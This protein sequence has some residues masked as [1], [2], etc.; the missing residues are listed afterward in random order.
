[1]ATKKKAG[2]PSNK[3]GSNSSKSKPTTRVKSKPQQRVVR[4]SVPKSAMDSGNPFSLYQGGSTESQVDFASEQGRR[5]GEVLGLGTGPTST[6]VV[7]ATV[8][9]KRSRHAVL[10]NP[11]A[12]R[13]I[14]VLVSNIVGSGHKMVSRA[15]DK[16]F[17]KQV[18][19]LWKKWCS[20]VDPAG[21][22]NFA[23]F[24]ALAFRSMLEGGD[25]FVRMRVRRPEDGLSV[26]LQLQVF[27][28]EQV[29]VQKNEA[30][31]PN[32]II[33]GIEFNPVGRITHYHMHRNH[34][35]EFTLLTSNQAISVDT[36]A[37]PSSEVI[38]LH[39][40]KRPNEVRGLPILSQSLIQLSDLDRY[41]DAELV[42][43][44][45]AALIGGFIKRPVDGS[46]STDPFIT[47]EGESEEGINNDPDSEFHIEALEPGTF[48]VLPDGYEVQFSTPTDVGPMFA[49]FLRQQ[50]LKIAAS[51]NLT[52]DQLTGDMSGVN[53]RTIRASM[54]EFKRIA[55]NYQE[56]VLVHQLCR[57]VFAKWFDLA[58]ISGA[59]KIPATMSDEDARLHT[60]IADPWQY[61]NPSQEVK[62]NI[63]KIRAG[64]ASRSQ[65]ITEDGGIPEDVDEQIRA[66]RER[67]KELGLVYTTNTNVISN[68]GNTQTS[69]PTKV[70]DETEEPPAPFTQF[71]GD[72]DATQD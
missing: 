58:V 15:P 47:T 27:E 57:T 7:N 54:L 19:D 66:E 8:A 28:S 21:K 63:E 67:E 52:Y 16:V 11:Y 61:M 22:L 69:D 14:D 10:T 50:L 23:A 70:G 3:S 59:L 71:D 25:S 4:S 34:P 40:V 35:G 60:W 36:F 53:D 64:L 56:N 24:E 37:I 30:K 62:T 13:A 38:H 49:V 45:A 51:V 65:T 1:M 72:E 39:D 41:M 32:N 18:E 20:E 55:M 33:A 68:S 5:G 46:N 2:S 6:T 17:K 29:P 31:G 9:R 12:K 42:R 26:P 43:K 44:K 48:P